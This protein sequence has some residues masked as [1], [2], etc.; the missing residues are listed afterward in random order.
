MQE[1]TTIPGKTYAVECAG[2][3]VITNNETG[4]I[5]AQGDGSGQVLFTA[6][7]NS[8]SVSD[9]TAKVV[10]LFKVAPRLKL[11]LLQGVAG[12][13]LPKGYTALEYLESSGTQYINT[14]HVPD[15]TTGLYNR[16]TYT[17][18]SAGQSF[19]VKQS[20]SQL[21]INARYA[22][23][24]SNGFGWNTWNATSSDKYIKSGDVVECSVNWMNNRRATVIAP[25]R[26]NT[27]PVTMFG[28]SSTLTGVYTQPI[29]L[30]GLNNNGSMAESSPYRMFAARIS[31]GDAVIR[32]F[33][34][35]LDPTGAPCMF[36]LV[37]RKAFYNK[38]SGDFLYPTERT[39]FALRRVLPD[40]GKLT[41]HGLRRLYHAPAYWQ[42][43][44][45]D[46]AIENGF[47]PIIEPEKPEEGYWT[48]RWTETEDE[49]VLEWVE[50]E[51]PMDE[52]ACPLEEL[53]TNN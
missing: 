11:T 24:A 43:E 5:A 48:P 44:L 17:T 7:G 14:Q 34:P 12:G 20:N 4:A 9:D 28:A 6:C 37:T 45:Y 51:P 50:T 21:L 52:L 16:Y 31:S 22:L 38:G 47:K 3:V 35:A 25:N 27:W 15:T 32:D 49:I 2:E 8:Y 36:D 40:W 18:S 46:Y 42:G 23:G 13:L 29:F 26:T 53:S 39:T 1:V 30:F 33:I 19:G 10:A 41:E